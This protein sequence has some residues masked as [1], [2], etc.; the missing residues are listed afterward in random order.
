[1]STRAVRAARASGSGGEQPPRRE[2]DDDQYMEREAALMRRLRDV[3]YWRE[4]FGMGTSGGPVQVARE[5]ADEAVVDDTPDV[6]E[7]LAA[8]SLD[9]DVNDDEERP[10]GGIASPD[11]ATIEFSFDWEE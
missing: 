1:M 4:Q 5:L 2:I 10:R 3:R 7:T 8:A 9:P 6:A 11:G